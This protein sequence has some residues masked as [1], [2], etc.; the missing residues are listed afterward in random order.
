MLDQ[1]GIG[2]DWTFGGGTALMLQIDHRLSHDVDIFL[3]DPQF[4]GYLDPAKLDF[5]FKIAPSSYKGDGS[6]F[7]KIVFDNVGEIDFIACAQMTDASAIRTEISGRSVMLETIAEIIAKKVYYRGGHIKAR[8]IFDIAAA[9]H[10]HRDEVV[11]VLA[12]M[13]VKV[14][15]TIDTARKFNAEAYSAIVSDLQIRASFEHLKMASRSLSHA[16]M[17]MKL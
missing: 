11:N 13:P 7:Q 2:D 10:D 16:R 15:T 14:Q 5:K 9:C 6:R 17:R 1:S 8:D 3:G 4:V 12:E